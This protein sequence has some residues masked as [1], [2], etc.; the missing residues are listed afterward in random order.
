VYLRNVLPDLKLIP[1][2]SL[3]CINCA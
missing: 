2:R 1:T 3:V